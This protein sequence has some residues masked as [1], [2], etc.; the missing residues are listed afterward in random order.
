[1]VSQLSSFQWPKG[2]EQWLVTKSSL[3]SSDR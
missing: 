1:M 2:S 3:Y